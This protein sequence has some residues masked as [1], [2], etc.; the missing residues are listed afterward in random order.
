[1]EDRPPLVE[2]EWLE[3]GRTGRVIGGGIEDCIVADGRG[4]VRSTNETRD[5]TVEAC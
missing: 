4:S 5:L 1:M 2:S 3:V